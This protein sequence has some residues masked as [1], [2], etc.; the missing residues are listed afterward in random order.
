MKHAEWCVQSPWAGWAAVPECYR[1]WTARV[2]VWSLHWARATACIKLLGG[3]ENPRVQNWVS[4]KISSF[5]ES[6]SWYSAPHLESTVKAFDLRS[7]SLHKIWKT[8]TLSLCRTTSMIQ[9][10]KGRPWNTFQSAVSACYLWLSGK[11]A[12][13][14]LWNWAL[15]HAWLVDSRHGSQQNCINRKAANQ[16]RNKPYVSEL[17]CALPTRGSR[18]ICHLRCNLWATHRVPAKVRKSY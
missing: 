17:S 10:E 15:F 8:T 5:W 3:T 4:D 18:S 9:E 2:C 6:C 1:S 16:L 14:I 13:K 12:G 7:P 11:V